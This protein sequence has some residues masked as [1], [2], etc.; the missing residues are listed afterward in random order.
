M[1]RK[2]VSLLTFEEIFED[3]LFIIPSYQR[4]YSWESRQRR[5][6]LGDIESARTQDYKHFTGTIVAA[7]DSKRQELEVVD[8][9]QRLTSLLILLNT[10]IKDVDSIDKPTK[11][12]L[13]KLFNFRVIDEKIVRVFQL[14]VGS[15]EVYEKE[16]LHDVSEY[17]LSVARNKSWYNILSAKDE[18]KNWARDSYQPGDLDVILNKL[19]FLLFIPVDSDTVGVMFEVINN[20]GKQL[21]ELEKI[22]N[23]LIYYAIR[24]KE[25]GLQEKIKVTWQI[26][27]E[28]LMQGGYTT[29]DDE[30]AFLRNCWILFA[31]TDK[32]R[33]HRV[34]EGMKEKFQI[35]DNGASEGRISDFLS[36]LKDGS[37]ALLK[38]NFPEGNHH[39]ENLRN[40]HTHASIMPL[41]LSILI[42]HK[43]NLTPI[44]TA[45]EY[46]EKLNFRVYVLP[47]ITSKSNKGQGDLFFI[48]QKYFLENY[49]YATPGREKSYYKYYEDTFPGIKE[50]DSIERAMLIFTK[51][52][53]PK[54]KMVESLTLDLDEDYDYYGWPSL[55]YFL[56]TYEID[57]NQ[58]RKVSY[59]ELLRSK[60]DGFK[61]DDLTHREHLWAKEHKTLDYDEN[62]STHEKKRL[63]NFALLEGGINS[64]GQHLDIDRKIDLYFDPSRSSNMQMI[65]DLR[66]EFQSAEKVFLKDK[67]FKIV[68]RKPALYSRLIDIREEKMVNWAIKTW[69]LPTDNDDSIKICSFNGAHVKH[70]GFLPGNPDNKVY[71]HVKGE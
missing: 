61:P 28:N 14:G 36:L 70:R 21:S 63:G 10:I 54:S 13:K 31:T 2:D 17:E 49:P 37:E 66:K 6:L 3:R 50:I 4:G 51:S 30:N 69:K 43:H 41:L 26:I 71:L 42:I 58:H 68:D 67:P 60:E 64:K 40:H 55:K 53:C 56:S 1:P 44:E 16:I 12:R 7:R 34:Y 46:L 9:Q 35:N 18:F 19:G 29:N 25:L 39:L 20:R 45:L 62:W 47:Q 48:A 57:L 5:D 27:L 33:S 24:N 52:L 22:K 11:D 15:D 23:Y 38:F 59:N 65:K 32:N 8:G